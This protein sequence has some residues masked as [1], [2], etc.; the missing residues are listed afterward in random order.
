MMDNGLNKVINVLNKKVF[1]CQK[2]ESHGETIETKFLI[3]LNFW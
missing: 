2:V 3:D 1:L